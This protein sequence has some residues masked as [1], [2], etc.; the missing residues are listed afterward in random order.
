MGVG[1][2]KW[3]SQ[4][5]MPLFFANPVYVPRL[6][7][8]GS[9]PLWVLCERAGVPCSASGA[10]VDRPIVLAHGADYAIVAEPGG[11]G[12]VHLQVPAHVP[13]CREAARHAL[14]MLAYVLFD[15]VARECVCGQP[16]ARP[17]VPRDD[18]AI[19]HALYRLTD[20]PMLNSLASG[21]TTATRLDGRAC[22]A[23]YETALPHIIDWEAV[24]ASERVF[25]RSLGIAFT[26]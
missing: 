22:R 17:V 23:I 2:R 18:P 13:R 8:T 3:Q 20:Y 26:T 10:W 4:M 11:F 19:I 7:R 9:I 24:S 5:A 16:W 6:D 1:Y 21:R 12:A 15:P 25:M 14:A